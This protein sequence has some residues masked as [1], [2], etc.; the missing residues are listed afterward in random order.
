MIEI[1]VCEY[2]LLCAVYN[3]HIIIIVYRLGV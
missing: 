1:L 2:S 3:T